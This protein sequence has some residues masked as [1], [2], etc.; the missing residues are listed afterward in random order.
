MKNL[1]AILLI[2]CS[3][4]IVAQTTAIPDANFEQQLINLGLDS[5]PIDGL[6]T[7]ANIDTVIN[8][9]VFNDN[10][11]DL[12]GIE[13]FTAITFLN[14]RDN[15]LTSL[16][17]TQNLVLSVLWCDKNQL[18]SL[19]VTQNIALSVLLCDKNQLPNLD[20]T[21][22]IALAQIN[23]SSNLLTSLDVTQNL[24]L[25]MLICGFN[26]ITSIDLSQNTVLTFL[27]MQLTLISSLDLTNNTL[28]EILD[29]S[30]NNLTSLNLTQ[31]TV[32]EWLD[33]YLNQLT[34]VNIKNGNISNITNYFDVG[35][36]S[37]LTCLEVD[38]VAW[39]TT[40]LN[41]PSQISFSSNCGNP[42]STFGVGIDKLTSANINLHP[43]PTYGQLSISLEK[44]TATSVTLRNSLG[45]L[46]LSDKVKATNQI[47]IDLSTYPIGIYFLQ[48]EVDGKLITK[49]VVKE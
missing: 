44:G 24:S 7:T 47:A 37:N 10:I 36:N 21:Q 17:V 22:N 8:L 41:V 31:N 38:D 1:L 4:F 26:N 34:C 13:D 25:Q 6:V 33:L 30:N 46:L 19:D 40:N 43:N 42:C 49:K 9:T 12:S 39:A 32:L 11:S 3:T 5:G 23:C 2:S 45:Q 35:G 16:D 15:L 27:Q 18:A 28:L 29:I 14:C 48:L 20:V